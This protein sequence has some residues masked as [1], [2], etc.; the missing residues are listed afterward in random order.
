MTKPA[1]L[2]TIAGTDPSGGAGVQVDLNV[3]RDWGFHG[4]SVVTA[5]VAQNTQSVLRFES[6]SGRLVRDQLATL[7]EDVSP[8]GVK[9]GMLSSAEAVD[10]IATA[11]EGLGGEVPVVFDPVMASGGHQSLRR[12]GT[13]EAMRQRLFPRVDVLTPNV[14]EAELLLDTTL[15][16]VDDLIA[17][18][19]ALAESGCAVLLKAGHLHARTAGPDEGIADVLATRAGA[20]RLAALEPIDGDIRGTGCQ[21]SSALTA[22]LALGMPLPEA[23]ETARRYLNDLLHSCRRR[24]GRGRPVIVRAEAP[25]NPLEDR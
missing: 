15:S 11:L 21:L 20:R 9:I 5:V 7:L 2:L 22:A 4:L 13:V 17:A 23:V 25:R 3:F 24:V 18:A 6:L 19:E 12:P 10:E 1:C 16:D 14:P 8:V